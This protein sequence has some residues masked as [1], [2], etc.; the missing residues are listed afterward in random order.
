MDSRYTRR[1]LA[2]REFSMNRQLSAALLLILSTGCATAFRPGKPI[3]ASE[4]F[5][6]NLYLQ[7]GKP[8]RQPSLYEGLEAVDAS[9]EEARTG[10]Y[11]MIGSL[12][13]GGVGGIGVGYGVFA[14][15]DGKKDAWP[16]LGAGL[17]VSAVGALLGTVAERH[18]LAAVKAY[19]AQLPAPPPPSAPPVS[20]VPYLAPVAQVDPNVRARGVEGGL[21]LR[22]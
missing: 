4:S 17:A 20:V 11:W 3:E 14:L 13:V 5:L 10:R 1:R 19:N 2:V 22:F 8:V 12:T 18:T 15:F 16:Y 7:E 6:G 21:V 9:R